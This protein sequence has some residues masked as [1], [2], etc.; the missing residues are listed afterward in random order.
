M[1]IIIQMKLIIK[2]FRK[3]KTKEYLLL[4]KNNNDITLNAKI[5]IGENEK[6]NKVNK[7]RCQYLIDSIVE[8]N[9]ILKYGK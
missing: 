1:D 4:I 7:L 2:N 3:N 9:R 8:T 5:A 6:Y